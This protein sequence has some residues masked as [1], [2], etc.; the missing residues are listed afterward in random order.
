MSGRTREIGDRQ[1]AEVGLAG[2]LATGEG[3]KKAGTAR[4]P[5]KCCFSHSSK[6][7]QQMEI[8]KL[9]LHP[10]QVLCPISLDAEPK[11]GSP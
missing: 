6:V 7:T 9:F 5:P 8:L 10:A 1:G 11:Q 2:H 4:S 3:E